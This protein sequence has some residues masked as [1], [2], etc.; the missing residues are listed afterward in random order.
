[1]S[2]TF[3]E[4]MTISM[5]E[6]LTS[7]NAFAYRKYIQTVLIHLV[8]CQRRNEDPNNHDLSVKIRMLFY[9]IVTGIQEECGKY[10]DIDRIRS[11][12]IP[13]LPEQ[14]DI[15]CRDESDFLL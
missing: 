11:E 6:F 4:A 14:A 7:C 8:Y 9:F 1:M 13:H 12:C 5:K 15:Q 2:E 3:N 10:L